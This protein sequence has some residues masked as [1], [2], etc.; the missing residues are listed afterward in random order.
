MLEECEGQHEFE[1]KPTYEYWP[2]VSDITLEDFKGRLFFCFSQ[3]LQNK[4][5]ALRCK[6][7]W[8]RK[9]TKTRGNSS[10]N[11][12]RYILANELHQM[13]DG[14]HLRFIRVTSEDEDSIHVTI[15]CFSDS[16]GPYN[17][18]L[19]FTPKTFE[20]F[21]ELVVQYNESQKKQKEK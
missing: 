2:V 5:G 6:N 4:L 19:I 13:E 15:F 14:C 18:R 7:C 1:E 21:T 16:V 8:E 17:V 10:G 20:T 9:V 12:V 3:D 11:E